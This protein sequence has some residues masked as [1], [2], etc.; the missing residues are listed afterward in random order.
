MTL[1]EAVNKFVTD[2]IHIYLDEG[3]YVG[4]N[5][6]LHFDRTEYDSLFKYGFYEDDCKEWLIRNATLVKKR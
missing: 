2:H 6:E 4:N 3:C 1:E 5:I